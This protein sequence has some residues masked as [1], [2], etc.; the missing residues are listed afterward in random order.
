MVTVYSIVNGQMMDLEVSLDDVVAAGQLGLGCVF[1]SDDGYIYS[2]VD[3]KVI[4]LFDQLH[5]IGIEDDDGNQ[6][7]IHIGYD[8][9]KNRGE[10]LIAFVK[11]HDLVRSHQLLICM[12]KSFLLKKTSSLHIL[13]VIAKTKNRV[14]F[15]HNSKTV[16]VSS[17]TKIIHLTD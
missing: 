10:G 17:T 6:Y 13:F 16:S 3:G 11:L 4:M 9:A 1:E 7:F 2:P 5:A 12:D 8:L 14:S 15:L